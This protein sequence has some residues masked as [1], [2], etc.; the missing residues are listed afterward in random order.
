MLSPHFIMTKLIVDNCIPS[1]TPTNLI[2]Y[3]QPAE[4]KW[5]QLQDSP[6]YFES[7]DSIPNTNKCFCNECRKWIQKSTTVSNILKHASSHSQLWLNRYKERKTKPTTIYEETQAKKTAETL[8]RFWILTGQPFHLIEDE[9]LTP[10]SRHLPNRKEIANTL[11]QVADKTKNEIKKE[12]HTASSISIAFDIWEDSKSRR[13]LGITSRAL[14]GFDFQN[15]VLALKPLYDEHLSSSIISDMIREILEEY[16]IT[17]KI[18]DCVS[19]NDS[20]MNLAAEKLHLYRCPCIAHLF[21]TLFKSFFKLVEKEI[22]NVMEL[23]ASL[24]RS[25]VYTAFCEKNHIKKV[26]TYVEIRWTSA[27]STILTLLETKDQIN[28]FLEH[29]KIEQPPDDQWTKLENLVPFLTEYKTIIAFYEKDAFGATG[30]F[31]RDVLLLTAEVDKLE[32]LEWCQPAIKSFHEKLHFLEKKHSDL[33]HRVAPIAAML[34]PC[35]SFTKVYPKEIKSTIQSEIAR[36]VNYYKPKPTKKQIIEQT[37]KKNERES[38]KKLPKDKSS[39]FE[40]LN[41]SCLESEEDLLP[42]WKTQLHSAQYHYLALVAIDFLGILC[43]SCATER[44]FSKARSFLTFKRMRI[45]QSTANAQA[46]VA[47]NRRIAKQFSLFD[48]TEGQ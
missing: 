3:Y 19:D 41:N 13:Y 43:T 17:S 1:S 23:S 29:E 42:F 15:Y 26:P 4:I 5:M 8:A 21:N 12:M 7:N 30:F 32:S 16:E 24:N 40:F 14:V 36:R 31:Q 28:E 6:L 27:C 38:F 44:S 48:F 45:K 10:I 34:N 22:K 11:A 37:D 9:E 18:T 47:G 2:D 25:T 33:F 46:I 35:I 20:V 39:I